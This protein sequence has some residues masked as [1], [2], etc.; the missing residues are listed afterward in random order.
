MSKNAMKSIGILACCLLFCA[1]N[2][3][4]A[5]GGTGPHASVMLRDGTR[6]SGQVTSSSPRQIT[7]VGD[8]K[9]TRTFDMTQVRSVEYDAPAEMDHTPDTGM[10]RQAPANPPTQEPPVAA[11]PVPVPDHPLHERPAE[12]EIRTRSYVVAAGT[13]LPVRVEETIDSA[14]A[15]E[16]QTFAA[17]IARPVMDEAGAVVLPRGANAVVVI[18]SASKGGRFKGASDLVLDVQSV[19]VGGRRYAVETVDLRRKGREGVGVNK[20]T[21]EYV[22]IGSAIGAVI[23]A[24]AGGGKGAAIGAGSGAGGGALA[25]VLTK[26]QAIRIPAETVLT[27]RLEAPLRVVAR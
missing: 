5:T 13:E 20:R 11:A 18:R 8:D 26:G 3:D 6:V 23:G 12:S 1:C 4:A 25:Q 15:V 17:E 16:G 2:R 19:S 9:T 21:G 24:I 7:L 22:G 14:R 27:F 10:A